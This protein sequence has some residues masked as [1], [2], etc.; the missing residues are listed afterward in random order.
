MSSPDWG[1]Y[2]HLPW[3]R[4]RCPYCAFVLDTRPE[5]PHAAYTEALLREWALR[6]G[7]YEGL[8]A[9]ASACF[10]GGTP[11]LTPAGELARLVEAFGVVAGGEVSMEA[12]PGDLGGDAAGTMAAW[13][14]AGVTRL[15]LGVQSLDERVARRLGRAHEARDAR[16]LVEAAQRGGF[17][18]VS[19]DLIFGVPGQTLADLDHELGEALALAPDHVSL[20][21][22][23]IEPDTAFGRRGVPAADE[24]LWRAMYERAVERLALAG[25]DRYEVSNFARAGHRSRHN[26]HYWRARP[27]VGLGVGAHGWQP[28]GVRTANGPDVDAYLAAADPRGP[29]ERPGPEDLAAELIGSTLR[30]VDGVD[31]A[32]LRAH[33]GLDVRVPEVLIRGGQVTLVEGR[34]VL[35]PVAFAV[36]DLVASRLCGGLVPA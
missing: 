26:E 28:D 30:H 34:I 3:C 5:R 18:S 32:L 17:R 23:T 35:A 15:S 10:G 16:R 8:G 22:L 20:Y 11:S 14:D 4:R 7:A 19:F 27:Y 31:R 25:L 24:D 21:G 29:S 13:R 36:A 6:R 33:T 12:N 9:P 2:V 1:V